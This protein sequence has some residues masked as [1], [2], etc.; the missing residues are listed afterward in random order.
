MN[1]FTVISC[2]LTL[3]IFVSAAQSYASTPIH[4]EVYVADTNSYCVT[5]T[6]I[7]GAR[8]AILVDVQFRKSEAI[9]LADRI[10]AT[11]KQLKA[12]IISHPDDD[13]YLC[14]AVFRERFPN[15]PIYMSAAAL[16]EF[17]RT[18]TKYFKMMKSYSPTET[19]DSLP[20]PELLPSTH[21]TVDGEDVEVIAD[22]QGDTWKPSN[23]YLW[24][25]SSQTI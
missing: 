6:L 18:S 14:M 17:R 25:P 4:C 23:S 20:T 15:T 11:G 16:Q 24:I 2:L 5:S 7:S 12:I 21:F 13:H 3:G 19:P 8:E 22:V 10:A 9:K 1:K